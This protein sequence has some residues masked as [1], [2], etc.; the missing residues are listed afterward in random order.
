MFKKLWVCS[1]LLCTGLSFSQQTKI[2]SL[3]SV[4]LIDSKFELKREN[5]GKVVTKIT[6]KELEKSA[7]LTIPDLI[8]SVSGIEINGTRSNDGQNLGYYIRG[9]RNR[10]VSN[11]GRWGAIK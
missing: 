7:G 5:S 1:A 6:A 10:Q 8:N 9:G 3:D 11:F 4:V 2:E